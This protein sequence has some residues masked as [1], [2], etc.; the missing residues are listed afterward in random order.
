MSL[1]DKDLELAIKA[2]DDYFVS[3][4]DVPVE[5]ATIKREEWEAVKVFLAERDA[6]RADKVRELEINAIS[7]AKFNGRC[8]V[9]IKVGGKWVK[10]IEDSG[11]VISHIVEKSGIEKAIEATKGSEDE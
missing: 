9:S 7:L 1:S 6:Q 4:N 5:R 10:V 11:T 2:I 8:E 3:G